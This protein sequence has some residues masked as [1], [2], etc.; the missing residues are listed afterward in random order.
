MMRARVSIHEPQGVLVSTQYISIDEESPRRALCA[1]RR[2]PFGSLAAAC[3]DPV[4]ALGHWLCHRHRHP[5]YTNLSMSLFLC[6]YTLLRPTA[7]G[8]HHQSL[9]LPPLGPSVPKHT[10]P[11][12]RLFSSLGIFDDSI[13]LSTACPPRDSHIASSDL[14]SYI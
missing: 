4:R 13:P 2:P 11:P 8:P 3:R 12:P 9:P 5:R 14:L 10:L 7:L 6:L 1:K